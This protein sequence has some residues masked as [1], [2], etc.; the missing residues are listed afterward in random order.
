MVISGLFVSSSKEELLTSNARDEQRGGDSYYLRE[1]WC[2][3]CQGQK[4]LHH[5]KRS[6]A[7]L[8]FLE[9]IDGKKSFMEAEFLQQKTWIYQI[10][11]EF[12]KLETLSYN[13][14]GCLAF[15]SEDKPDTL[16]S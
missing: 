1:W 8:L 5:S 12:I 11:K 16:W 10:V 4:P 14:I 15:K 13:A 2:V 9:W 6:K 7:S 3:D